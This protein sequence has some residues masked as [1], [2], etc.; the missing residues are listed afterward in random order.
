MDR[1]TF[2]HQLAI[3][4]GLFSIEAMSSDCAAEEPLTGSD[5]PK[6]TSGEPV[7]VAD[8]QALAAARLPTPCGVAGSV[9]AS[10]GS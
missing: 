6:P 7:R 10:S 2:A 5:V 4:L 8:F 3:S 9:V 1:R